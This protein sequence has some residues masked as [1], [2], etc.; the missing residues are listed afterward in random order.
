MK[1]AQFSVAILSQLEEVVEQLTNDSYCNT[2][3]VFSGASIGQHIRHILEFYHCSL[4]Q[5]VSGEI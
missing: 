3:E 5:K 4:V 1:S 2:M